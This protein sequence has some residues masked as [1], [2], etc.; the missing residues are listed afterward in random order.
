MLSASLKSSHE[1]L[2][3][4]FDN[5]FIPTMKELEKMFWEYVDS[6]PGIK[7]R[8]TSGICFGGSLTHNYI[9][10]LLLHNNKEQY[11]P[12]IKNYIKSYN[13]YNKSRQTAGILFRYNDSFLVVQTNNG[14]NI[15]GMPKGKQEDDESI[16]DTA[17]REFYEETGIDVTE[18][19]HSDTLNYRVQKTLFFVLE[20]DVKVNV[21]N[22][23]TNEISGVKWVSYMEVLNNPQSYSKQVNKI[24]QMLKN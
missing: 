12:N 10:K 19:I 11:I 21:S 9:K 7:Y 24:A 22:F 8:F 20:T 13:K 18:F 17:C 14:L 23:K 2:L 15:W 6:S 3:L 5:N 16:E 4:D 1:S